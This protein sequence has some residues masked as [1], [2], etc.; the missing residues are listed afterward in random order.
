M[1]VL[2]LA[3]IFLILSVTAVD[4][5]YAQGPNRR[6]ESITIPFTAANAEFLSPDHFSFT[7]K[8]SGDWILTIQNNLRHNEQNPE[9]KVVIRLKEK[10]EDTTF[11]EMMMVGPPSHKLSIAISNK[12]IGYMRMFE[13]ENAW[14]PDKPI[15]ASVVQGERLSINNGQR[16]VLDRLQIG[17]FTPNTIEVYGRDGAE[18]DASAF[19]G[20]IIVDIVS[21]NP[22]DNPITMIPPIAV[23]ITAGALVTLL[24]IKKRT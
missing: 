9:A 7:A 11:V 10:P 18:A 8:P 4:V 6:T 15:M 5:V 16:T 13:N 21:G 2:V 1:K 20:E 12:E 24:V 19:S 14:F 17:A 22:L 23:A 3:V